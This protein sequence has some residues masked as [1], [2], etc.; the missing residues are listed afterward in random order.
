[1]ATQGTSRKDSPEIHIELIDAIGKDTQKHPGASD[2]DV[3]LSRNE[4]KRKEDNA[5]SPLDAAAP[6]AVGLEPASEASAL[7]DGG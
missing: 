7:G 5:S 1:M 2:W 6:A 3:L 4:P